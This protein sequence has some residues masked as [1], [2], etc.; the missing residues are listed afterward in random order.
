MFYI[1][2]SGARTSPDESLRAARQD[3]GN[4]FLSGLRQNNIQNLH[5][6]RQRHF[7]LVLFICGMADSLP[8]TFPWMSTD[9]MSGV[10]AAAV[11]RKAKTRSGNTAGNILSPLT[12]MP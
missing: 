3:C 2:A 10:L 6:S 5:E 12:E 8:S 1:K 9:D 7:A 4:N 11:E